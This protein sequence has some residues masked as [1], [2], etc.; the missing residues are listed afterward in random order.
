MRAAM[1]KIC[2]DQLWMRHAALQAFFFADFEALDQALGVR[3]FRWAL[4]AA[5]RLGHRLYLAA[6]CLGLG[7]CG[8]GA[9]Y[10]GEAVELLGLP[11][12]VGL[13]YAVALGP[14]RSMKD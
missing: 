6:E 7:A 10:D 1:A 4:Q 11:D 2:L 3:G 14:V 5:G 8:V 9:F 12:G 13:V